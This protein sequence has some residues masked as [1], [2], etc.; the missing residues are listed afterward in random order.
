MKTAEDILMEKNRDMICVSPETTIQEALQTMI[1][2]KIG[3]ILIKEGGK[4]VGIWTERDLMRNVVAPG[5][6]VTT[7]RIGHHMTK[8]LFAVQ[9]TAS[10]YNLKD[11]F[12]GRRLRHLLV[13][14]EGE[15]IGI[16]SAGDVMKATL[17]EK[18][19]ELEQLN[20]IV[21]WDYY[22]DW[23]WKRRKK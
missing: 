20:A 17:D 9:H 19:Q 18:S 1:E 22:E 15:Y 6:D 14:K 23:K 8:D 21:K 10:L 11:Q 3:A 4:L 7:A 2:R 13:E 12:L 5:F 16:L